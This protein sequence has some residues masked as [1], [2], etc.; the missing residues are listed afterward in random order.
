MSPHLTRTAFALAVLCTL[1]AGLLLLLEPAGSGPFWITL[2]TL[3]VAL[4]FLSLVVSYVLWVAH[5]GEPKGGEGA[6]S[7]PAA[8]DRHG[9]ADGL[10]PSGF[11]QLRREEDLQR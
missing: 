8:A 11:H 1:S 5:T 4:L 10:P 6:G 3:L 9:F 2:W 7:P